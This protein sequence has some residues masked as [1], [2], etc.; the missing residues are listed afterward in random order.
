MIAA[1]I[2]EQTSSGRRIPVVCA[3]LLA[4][5]LL[6]SCITTTTDGFNVDTS[7][8]QALQDY[9]RLAVAYYDSGDFAGARRNIHNAMQIDRRNSDVHTVLALIFQG[10]GDPESAEDNFRRAISLDRGN[11]RARNNYA[12]LLFDM[13]RYED[14][15]RQLQ[16]VTRDTDYAGRAI[17]FENLG[18]AALRIE[19]REAAASAFL[20]ALQLNGNLY[21]S[22]L[23]L[24]LLK[25]EMQDW[26]GAR[27]SYNQYLTTVESYN[28]PHTPRA[29]LAGIQIEGRFRNQ[30]IVNDFALILSTLYADTPEYRT[31]QRLG[32]AN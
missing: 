32:N 16:R 5:V 24:S 26:G 29:L 14:A 18:R 6:P 12:A 8:E 22:S 28:I 30:E 25:L 11:S 20:R 23:E 27:Q 31:Y 4:V 10:E 9:I 15:Y 21:V 2:E 7:E 3:V 17:A 13:G 1:V 19:H